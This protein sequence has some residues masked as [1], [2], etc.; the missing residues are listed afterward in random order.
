MSTHATIA[1]IMP[2]C[3][4]SLSVGDDVGVEVGRT[5]SRSVLDIVENSVRNSDDESPRNFVLVGN[6]GSWL[7]S[8]TSSVVVSEL[9]G[10]ARASWRTAITDA[11]T[12]AVFVRIVRICD[13]E[14]MV[15]LRK[16]RSY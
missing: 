10:G 16:K 11:V 3:K 14:Q 9:G 15:H 13:D 4:P 6:G 5:L 2:M 7:G 12:I 1:V 8:V